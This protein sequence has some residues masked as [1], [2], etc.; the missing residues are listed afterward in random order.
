[1]NKSF[2]DRAAIGSVRVTDDG[3]LVAQSKSARTGVQLYLAEEI[4]DSAYALGFKDGD[5][6]RVMRHESEVFSKDAMSSLIH[7]PVTID[8]PPVFIDSSNWDEY[9]VGEVGSDV[10]RDGESLVVSLVI[11]DADAV[12]S[13]T[14]THKELSWGYSAKIREYK[15]RSIADLEMYGFKYNHISAVPRGRAGSDHRIGDGDLK[16]ALPANVTKEEKTMTVELK[17]VILGDKAVRVEAKDAETV[18]GILKDH[19]SVIDA[20]DAKIGELEV[21]LSDAMSKILSDEEIDK[22]ISSKIESEN[23]RKAVID[24]VGDKAKDWTDAQIDGAFLALDFDIKTD[25]TARDA[26][27]DKKQELNADQKIQDAIKRRFNKDVK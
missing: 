22:M 25:D 12:K 9:A 16:W 24:K 27:S 1:M 11:K 17:T 21:K 26:I 2:S 13:A 15:D 19:K 4:G 5:V 23:K 6:V 8:H 18:A 10:L 14:T 3:F 7:A 20:K